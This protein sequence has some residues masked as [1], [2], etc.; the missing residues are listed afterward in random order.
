MKTTVQTV[1]TV[2]L[3]A[4]ML[5]GCTAQTSAPAI[6]E[7]APAPE[8]VALPLSAVETAEEDPM[9]ETYI[10]VLEGIYYD[11]VL[12]DGQRLEPLTEFF[13]ED[14]N[15]FA[16]YDVDGDGAEELIIRYVNTYTA[17]MFGVVYGYDRATD[18]LATQLLEFPAMSFYPNG[19]VEVG[20]SHNQGLAGR[21]W[22]CTFY[23]YS[24]ETDKYEAAAYVDAWDGAF[25]ET[26]FDG[27]P[28]PAEADTSGDNIVYYICR[29]GDESAP[30]PVSQVEFNR[31]YHAFIGFDPHQDSQIGFSLEIP[32]QPLTEENIL[33]IT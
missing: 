32:Y 4:A 27:N 14:P 5:G 17:G 20:W 8:P 31:W 11:Y 2:L 1:L 24:P 30:A 10:D 18:K 26:D 13:A 21:F 28:F 9:L 19:S 33:A 22:P 29:Y 25:F 3:A 23:Q 15:E 7:E 16:I 6:D 12:P